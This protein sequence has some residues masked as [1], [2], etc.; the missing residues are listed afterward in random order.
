MI[1]E[2]DESGEKVK[3]Q[4][5]N[6]AII[7]ELSLNSVVGLTNP[8]TIKL[9]GMIHDYRVVVLIDCGVPHNFIAQQ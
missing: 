4:A 7:V 6:V 9:G 2:G 8:G 3:L 5:A 1:E